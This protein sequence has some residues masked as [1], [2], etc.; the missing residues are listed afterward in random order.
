MRHKHSIYWEG[1]AAAL[2]TSISFCVFPAQAQNFYGSS[3]TVNLGPI[4]NSG[5]NNQHL[6]ISKD[7]L[8]VYYSSD[9]LAGLESSIYGS[10][11]NS[12]LMRTGVCPKASALTSFPH[13]TISHP[14]S[15]PMATGFI[16]TVIVPE[17]AAPRAPWICT[18]RIARTNA[19]SL[20][21]RL[22]KVSD[23]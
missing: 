12:A 15:L 10:Y 9:Q 19:T 2:I 20:A 11:S 14:R 1:F 17:D 5:V 6:A 16:S 3:A 4:T 21:G 8:S 7:G 23:E 22:T 13:V 18:F